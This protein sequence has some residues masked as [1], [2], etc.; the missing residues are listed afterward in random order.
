[1]EEK[2]AEVLTLLAEGPVSFEDLIRRSASRSEATAAFLAL[3]ELCRQGKVCLAG[4]MENPVIAKT[5]EV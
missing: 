2:A 1:M 4:E 3:L 5:P